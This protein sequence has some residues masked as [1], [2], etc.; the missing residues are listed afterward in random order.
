MDNESWEQF[1]F[2]DP[3]L[4]PAYLPFVGIAK[5]L[6]ERISAIGGIDPHGPV[7]IPD[8][9]DPSRALSSMM[10][11]DQKLNIVCRSYIRPDKFPQIDYPGDLFWKPDELYLAAADG[12]SENVI[13]TDVNKRSMLNFLYPVEWLKQRYKMINLLRYKRIDNEISSFYSEDENGATKEES[14]NNALSKKRVAYDDR[15]RCRFEGAKGT[16]WYRVAFGLLKSCSV[17]QFSQ[18]NSKNPVLIFHVAPYGVF[19]SF[20]HNVTLGWN[21]IPADEN[22][23]FLDID[24]IPFPD[25]WTNDHFICGWDSDR[26]H[27]SYADFNDS[28]NFKAPE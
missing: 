24:S 21:R 22:G 17:F 23:V 3:T 2:P 16:G 6:N 12:I 15:L 26:N 25:G 18:L 20:G 28:F 27:L 4:Y 19:Q 1:G 11:V 13:Y 7:V 14:F 5:A 8:V 9:F 10:D